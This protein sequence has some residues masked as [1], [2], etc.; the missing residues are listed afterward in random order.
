MLWALV[1]AASGF[2]RPAELHLRASEDSDPTALLQLCHLPGAQLEL[3]TRSNMLGPEVFEVLRRCTRP[4]VELRAPLR[5]AHRERLEKLPAVEPL[6]SFGPADSLDWTAVSA[7]GPRRVHLRLSGMLTPARA[8]ALARFRNTELLLDLRGRLPDAEELA[9]FRQLD[10][11]DRVFVIRADAPPE[12]VAGLKAAQPSGLV[13]QAVGNKVPAPML[14]AL[15]GADL[16]TRIELV[17]PF[18]AAEVEPLTA[19]R[20]LALEV[21]LGEIERLPAGFVKALA[22]VEPDL[23]APVH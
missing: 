22:P 10:R 11:A 8:D 7:L 17:W 6:F 1:L 20:R 5:A 4:E 19:I 14:R 3:G 18:S 15:A 23:S 12:L 21:D 9:R 2:L 13:V 16:P